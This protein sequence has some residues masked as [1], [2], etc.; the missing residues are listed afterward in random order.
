MARLK[1]PRGE[2]AVS[3][4]VPENE[5]TRFAGLPATGRVKCPTGMKP[6]SVC[7][8]KVTL[9]VLD[10][11]EGRTLPL[12]APEHYGLGQSLTPKCARGEVPV[13]TPRHMVPGLSG[14]GAQRIPLAHWEGTTLKVGSTPVLSP[15]QLGSEILDF[16]DAFGQL[17]RE[18]RFARIWFKK[19]VITV[20]WPGSKGGW[21][22]VSQYRVPRR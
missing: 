3:V 17:R 11:G 4:C 22:Q 18:T 15:D 6:V 7:P 19:D 9:T 16:D 5:P 10:E 8:S 14:L 12:P 13:C 21:R 1:C 20:Q 2:K